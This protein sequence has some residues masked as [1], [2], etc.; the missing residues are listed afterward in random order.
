MEEWEAL[1]Q[2]RQ[3]LSDKISK[4][5]YQV[6]KIDQRLD[7]LGRVAVS[8]QFGRYRMQE[9][10]VQE[11]SQNALIIEQLYAL[12]KFDHLLSKHTVL[13]LCDVN[14]QGFGCRIG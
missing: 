2:R 9:Q 8:E 3:M 12:G 11:I 13:G 4:I 1:I 6:E 10:F 14:L 7:F 5:S